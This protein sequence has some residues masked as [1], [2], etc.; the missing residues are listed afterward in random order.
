MADS[1]IAAVFLANRVM[2]RRLLAARTGD[3]A[4]ADDIIQEMWVRL[5]TARVGPVGE[6]LAYLMRMALNLAADRQLAARRR[7]AR[8]DAW[9]AL[10][11]GGADYPNAER[12]MA[13]AE[14]WARLQS[15]LGAMPDHMHRAL[16]L[17]RV[18]GRS[19][20]EIAQELGMSV[21]G[22]E[23]LLARAYRL[24]VQFREDTRDAN[25]PDPASDSHRNATHD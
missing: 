18:E 9:V 19:Q 3:P 15:L 21:S 5:E 1:G 14:E 16:V 23:K 22:V 2:V 11:P 17:F 25:A 20:R 13:S 4:E 7:L 24:L 12:S 8:D 6:P 10:Q